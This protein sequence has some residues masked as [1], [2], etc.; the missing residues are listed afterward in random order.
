MFLSCFTFNK[1]I[2]KKKTVLLQ[3]LCKAFNFSLVHKKQTKNKL[4][5]WP[6]DKSVT[7]LCGVWSRAS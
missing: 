7:F 1:R 3:A 6:R 5:I 2:K 4:K